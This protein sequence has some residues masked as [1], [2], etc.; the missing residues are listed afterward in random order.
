MIRDMEE[1]DAVCISSAISFSSHIKD[2]IQYF[3]DIKDITKLLDALNRTLRFI[4]NEMNVFDN[5]N[6]PDERLLENQTLSEKLI[7]RNLK[8]NPFMGRKIA[9][10]LNQ[11]VP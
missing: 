5:I 11:I 6:F 8:L 9:V 1:L 2:Y 7:K 10:F 3:Y 4:P